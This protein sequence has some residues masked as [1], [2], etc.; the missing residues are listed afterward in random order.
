MKREVIMRIL[1]RIKRELGWTLMDSPWGKRVLYQQ[2]H[3]GR[4]P[5]SDNGSNN[6]SNCGDEKEGQQERT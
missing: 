2:M 6:G 4:L 3:N 1:N 5:R